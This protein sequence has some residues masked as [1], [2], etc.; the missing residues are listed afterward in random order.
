MIL[1][2][3][4]IYTW[5]PILVYI[6]IHIYKPL[7]VYVY[8]LYLESGWNIF[9]HLQLV[10]YLHIFWTSRSEDG[11]VTPRKPALRRCSSKTSPSEASTV[12]SGAEPGKG[13]GKHKGKSKGAFLALLAVKGKGKSGGRGAGKGKGKGRGR[14]GTSTA[15]L[16]TVNPDAPDDFEYQLGKALREESESDE[17]PP[18]KIAAAGK[19]KAKKKANTVSENDK[20]DD[21]REAEE[22]R[23]KVKDKTNTKNGQTAEKKRKAE[24]PEEGCDEHAEISPMKSGKKFKKKKSKKLEEADGEDTPMTH[25]KNRKTDE[26][27]KKKKA[28]RDDE[29]HEEEDPGDYPECP[30]ERRQQKASSMEAAGMKQ[31]TLDDL[32]H[33]VK[34]ARPRIMPKQNQSPRRALHQINLDAWRVE[35]KR[36]EEE[37]E[38]EK[39]KGKGKGKGKAKGKHLKGKGKGKG[40]AEKTEAIEDSAV[41]GEWVLLCFGICCISFLSNHMA[42]KRNRKCCIPNVLPLVRFCTR[43]YI[44]ILDCMITWWPIKLWISD[45]ACRCWCSSWWWFA[46][47]LFIF[48]FKTLLHVTQKSLHISLLSVKPFRGNAL[49]LPSQLTPCAS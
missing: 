17:P 2:Y 31:L 11:Y 8:W 34:T 3:I 22:P 23:L 18:R 13:S 41:E 48:A 45:V 4:Y 40:T 33:V 16:E 42:G 32:K 35:A 30:E 49:K 26:K 7:L 47:W 20:E 27:T 36:T 44:E 15:S 43:Y 38:T 19:T 28:P 24:T 9:V 12:A 39:L 25:E 6:Y 46:T 14:G 1:V 29:E 37:T 21:E 5:K 10:D